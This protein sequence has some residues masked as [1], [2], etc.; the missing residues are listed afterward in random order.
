MCPGLEASVH[1]VG[2]YCGC[3]RRQR[4]RTKYS[5]YMYQSTS[6]QTQGPCSSQEYGVPWRSMSSGVQLLGRVESRMNASRSPTGE[7]PRWAIEW[8]VGAAAS[9]FRSD[10]TLYISETPIRTSGQSR[11]LAKPWAVRLAKPPFG[12]GR[13]APAQPT[14]PS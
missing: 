6:W 13:A 11:D 10:R 1:P 3:R 5:E 7:E 14:T 9:I 8:D 4:S 12:L 2:V